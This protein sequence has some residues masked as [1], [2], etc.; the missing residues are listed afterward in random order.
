MRKK[1]LLPILGIAALVGTGIFATSVVKANDASPYPPIVQNLVERFGLNEKEV[2]TFFDEQREE[3][4]QLRW[5]NREEKLNR[6]VEDGVITAEQMEAFQAKHQ[7]METNR[8]Q[9]REEMKT[10][11]EQQGIDVE[12]LREYGGCGG[13]FGPKHGKGW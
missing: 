11:F 5:Q 13:D 8:K 7:E 1:I 3:R 12:A 10:W 2:Q 4:Q 6:A 9:H